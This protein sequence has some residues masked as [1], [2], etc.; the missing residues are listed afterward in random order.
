[1]TTGGTES[2]TLV[3]ASWVVPGE[4]PPLRRGRVAVRQGRIVWVGPAE[5]GGA[6]SGRVLDLGPGVLLPGLVNAHC[7]L[8]LSL[9]AGRLDGSAGFVDWV[10]R[11][12]AAREGADPSALGRS[13]GEAIRALVETGTAAVGDV[14]NTLAH[15]ELLA[16]A[17]LEAVVF[18]ELIGWDPAGAERIL[19][20][21]EARLA[22][23]PP[24]LPER[25]VRVRLAAHAPHSVSPALF[26]ALAS[27]E[28]PA[29]V[30]LAESPVES[31]FLADGD[32]EWDAFLA[33]RGVGGVAFTPPGTSPVRYLDGLDLLRP[34]LLAVHCVQVDDQDIRL[35]ASHDVWAVLCP[36]S[37]LALQAGLPPLPAMIRAG[38]RLA[39]GTDSL[40]SVDSLDLLQ[41]AAALARA[42][43]EVPASLLVRM[44][45][46]GGAAALGLADLGR[47]APGCRAVLAFAPTPV[48]VPDPCAF[49]VSGEA[50]LQR[51]RP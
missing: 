50:R 3:Q 35:L 48:D 12:V 23:L 37:N 4:G 15:L 45:T 39:L 22:R 7:H 2:T 32:A 18:H 25:G 30:H 31:R 26:R 16:Q 1:M 8:E 21:A 6:P 47:L 40:A 51:L 36:R 49:L 11:L 17:D 27:R 28:G 46:A 29:S 19:A 9:W 44:A 5:D 43:P 38:V 10:R 42:F 24:D 14:S 33:E 13:A 34:G 41:D 20:A